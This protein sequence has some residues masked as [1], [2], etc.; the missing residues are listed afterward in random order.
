MSATTLFNTIGKALLTI[1]EAA[2]LLHVSMTTMRRYID[3]KRIAICKPGGKR[4]KIYIRPTDLE[5]FI[6]RSRRSAIGE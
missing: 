1:E 4:G 6:L 2:E 3:Q 5:A